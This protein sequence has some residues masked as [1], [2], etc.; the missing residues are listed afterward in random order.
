MDTSNV[1][2]DVAEAAGSAGQ[3]F[4]GEL[5][6]IGK[7]AFSQLIGASNAQPLSDEELEKKKKSDDDFSQGEIAQLRARIASIYK[8]YDALKK[9]EEKLEEEQEKQEEEFKKLEE[10]N[11]LRQSGNAVNV[12][13]KTAVGKASAETGKSYGNE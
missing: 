13:V 1:A 4:L 5:K 3:G 12:N 6:K 9:K 10:I 11:E 2:G 7:T 8:G